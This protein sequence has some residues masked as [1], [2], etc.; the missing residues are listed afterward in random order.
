MLS[1]RKS[2]MSSATEHKVGTIMKGNDYQYWV[3]DKTSNGTHRWVPSL[4]AEINNM[5]LLTIDYLAKNIN[6]PIKLYCR[7]YSSAWPKKTDKNIYIIKFTP[8][9]NALIGKKILVDWLKTRKPLIP[10]R[11]K[12]SIEG[13]INFYIKK[14]DVQLSS[15]QVDTKN[16]KQVSTNLMNTEVFY[17]IT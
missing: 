15:L 14:E 12:F 8:T 16:K 5:K 3:V 6:K 7:E 9:G 4:N 11:S 13:Y 2:P 10:D 1:N 17:F